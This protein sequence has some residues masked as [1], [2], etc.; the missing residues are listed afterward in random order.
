M[1]HILLRG[2]LY[3]I[4]HEWGVRRR[5]PKNQNRVMLAFPMPSAFE[6]HFLLLNDGA[7][8]W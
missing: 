6:R 4:N 1:T 3:P 8:M 7:R 5:T 2:I